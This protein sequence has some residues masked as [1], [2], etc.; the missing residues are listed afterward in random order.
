M[1]VVGL[2]GRGT[3][4]RGRNLESVFEF[5]DHG[6]VEPAQFGRERA[7]AIAL[8]MADERDV[9]DRVGDDANGAI[10]A[11]VAT[12]S[13]IEFIAT[14]TPARR[15]GAGDLDAVGCQVTRAPI[16]SS[17][18]RNAISPCT[19]FAISPSE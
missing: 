17:T 6:R 3:S 9:A 13:G 10:A 18:P 4:A 11:R 12:M 2:D 7:N 16:C 1:I 14:S 8:V 19:E 5:F 15:A